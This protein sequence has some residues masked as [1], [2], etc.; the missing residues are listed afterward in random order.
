MYYD[1]SFRKTRNSKDMDYIRCPDWSSAMEWLRE[2]GGSMSNILIF[3][4]DGEM[5]SKRGARDA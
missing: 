2:N 3:Q 5:P 4:F 1:I